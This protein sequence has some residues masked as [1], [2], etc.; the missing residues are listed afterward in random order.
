MLQSWAELL[1]ATAL[2]RAL[3]SSVW[4]YPLV[5]TAHVV[6]IALLFGGIAPLDLRLLGCW[7]GVPLAH[8]RRVL[9]PVS[10]TGLVLAVTSGALLFV[11]R[12]ADYLREPLFGV[13]LAL[14][15]LAVSNALALRLS[16]AWRTGI[17]TEPPRHWRWVAALSLVLWLGAITAGRFI[18]YR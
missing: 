2:S 15:G 5:N 16:P 14:V 13:K 1:Q 18:G 11:T 9:L 17:Q 4:L 10:I 12:P 3:G 8:L 7:R 6:G